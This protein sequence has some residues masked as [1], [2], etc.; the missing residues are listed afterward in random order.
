MKE[1]RSINL[2]GIVLSIDLDAYRTLSDYLQDI[3]L[4]LPHDEKEDV[5]V[6]VESRVAE[7]FQKGLFARNIQSVDI[8]MVRD[9]MTQIG[10][11]SEF[12][13]NKR[14]KVKNKNMSQNS[15]CSRAFGIAFKVILIIIGIWIL[16][17]VGAVVFALLMALMGIGLGFS[18]IPFAFINTL[19]F[20]PLQMVI[21]VLCAVAVLVL[22][23]VMIIHSTVSFV[24]TKHG[25]SARFW[26]ITLIL[27]CISIAGVFT[28]FGKFVK[29]NGG[30][31]N[32]GQLIQRTYLDDD[33]NASTEYRS[34]APFNAITIAGPVDVSIQQ[35]PF[36]DI[37]VMSQTLN[38]VITE[39]KD[40]MLMIR[41]DNSQNLY[42]AIDITMPNLRSI[43]AVG[44]ANVKINMELDSLD[45]RAI[46]STEVESKG[47]IAYLH[48][49]AS[50]AS[51]I[52]AKVTKSLWASAS[53]ASKISYIGSPKVIHK[54]ETDVSKIKKEELQ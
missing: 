25:P 3:E 22:P 13:S 46:G 36:Q 24:R 6:D 11:P 7:L 27:W 32:V 37:T 31:H 12:G 44:T 5:M 45:V 29:D 41:Y 1:T 33:A 4:R 8:Q 53:G 43:E 39:V 20:T 19:L 26:W 16:F 18:V 15:G 35:G 9:V 34:L 30:W 23:L 42:A 38:S 17:P 51:E 28:S 47:N 54:S 21:L 2:R 49:E 14:P 40:S 52:E 10:N 50:M 48:A